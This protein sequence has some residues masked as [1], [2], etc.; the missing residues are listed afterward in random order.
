MK[1]QQVFPLLYKEAKGRIYL[2]DNYPHNSMPQS[3]GRYSDREPTEVTRMRRLLFKVDAYLI[4]PS[5]TPFNL[6]LVMLA[7]YLST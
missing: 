2:L 1:L 6:P 3:P 5:I 4:N 7:I